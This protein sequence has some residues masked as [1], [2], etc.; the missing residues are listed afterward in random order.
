MKKITLFILYVISINLFLSCCTNSTDQNNDNQYTLVSLKGPSSMAILPFID[1]ISQ[2]TKYNRQH[3]KDENLDITIC[4]EPLQVRK[5]MLDGSADF[6]VLPM[7]TAALLYNKD[8]DYKIIAV[9][10]W[11]SL[12]LCGTDD[13]INDWDDLKDKNIF[14][15]AKGMTPDVLFRYLLKENGLTPYKDVNLDY[16][17]PTHIDLANAVLAGRADL[18]VLSEPFLSLAMLKNNNINRLFDLGDKWKELKGIPIAETALLC[19]SDIIEKKPEFVNKIIKIYSQSTDWVNNNI[20]EAASLAVRYNII[21]DS[22]A[23]KNSIPFSNLKVEKAKDVK[24]LIEQYLNVFYEMDP[25]I[26]GGK[27][28][29]EEFYQ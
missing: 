2:Q 16:R 20:N 19:K 21:D 6:A 1:S 25:Q 9:P 22:I 3:S 29:D 17:F 27:M 4:T 15:M 26:I 13:N 14:L 7:T 10:V 18:A 23:A 24:N 11:G 12:Y 8:I 5:M 28:P